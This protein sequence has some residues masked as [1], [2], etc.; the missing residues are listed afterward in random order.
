MK[1]VIFKQ[2]DNQ[3]GLLHPA[4]AFTDTLTGTE[5]EKLIHLADKD[6]PT[7]TVYEIVDYEDL[8]ELDMNFFDAAEYENGPNDKVSKDLPREYQF[9][10]ELLT[11]DDLTEEEKQEWL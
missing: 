4:P 3:L 5:E 10:Y 7:G 6:L 1:C 9:K 8:S 2:D 11:I